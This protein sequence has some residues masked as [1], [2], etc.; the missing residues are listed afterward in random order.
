MTHIN[1]A[2][3]L[4]KVLVRYRLTERIRSHSCDVQTIQLKKFETVRVAQSLR[5]HVE[6]VARFIIRVFVNITG[7]IICVNI[8]NRWVVLGRQEVK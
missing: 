4:T 7:F 5:I 8:C 3:S 6:I 1:H 2:L